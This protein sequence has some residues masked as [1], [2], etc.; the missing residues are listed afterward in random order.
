MSVS[1]SQ[2]AS[3]SNEAVN[4][5]TKSGILKDSKNLLKQIPDKLI[6]LEYNGNKVK[7]G[8]QIKVQTASTHPGL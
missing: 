2:P 1:K 6:S 5:F 4:I 8:E 3:S 7:A